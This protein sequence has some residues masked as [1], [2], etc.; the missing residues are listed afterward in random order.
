MADEQQSRDPGEAAGGP[1]QLR[2]DPFVE[3][4]RRD[5]S[6]PPQPVRVLE[7]LL[8]NSDR[9]GY[10][11]IYFTRELDTYAEFRAEDVV[12]REP[13]PPDQPPLQGLDAS[14]VGLRR[15]APVWYTQVRTPRPVDEFDLD[16]RL[17]RLGPRR[18]VAALAQ[19]ACE[20]HCDACPTCANTCAPTCPGT[21]APTCPN[22]CQTC[23]TRCGQETCVNTCRTCFTQ[24]DTCAET[25]QTCN[26]DC[27]TCPDDTC[28]G[29]QCNT[30]CN[31]CR[32]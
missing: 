14:R 1:E 16:I 27:G 11:R 15:E 20:T 21:C 30:H 17:A 4:L 25:C 13:I 7:G 12:Y 26:T 31:T 2:Q 10:H 32:C 24:C 23:D 9:A 18:G 19:T 6:Q 29:T 28:F 5:P 3:R 22:T 8:G